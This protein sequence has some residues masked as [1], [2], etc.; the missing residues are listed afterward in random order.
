MKKLIGLAVVLFLGVAAGWWSILK[1]FTENPAEDFRARGTFIAL[2]NQ[3]TIDM[4][5]MYNVFM[6][7]TNFVST[8][9]LFTLSN[10][11]QGAMLICEFVGL[12]G[13]TSVVCLQTQNGERIK[14]MYPNP[15]WFQIRGG[16]SYLL[17]CFADSPT[18][19]CAWLV[20]DDPLWLSKT[21]QTSGG[22]Q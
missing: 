8:D 13:R 18:N 16:Y 11:T 15:G 9:S 7:V 6:P 3:Y 14:W 20:S 2:E 5:R 19:V 10:I 17:Q 21:V 22:G 12:H 1:R 4:A